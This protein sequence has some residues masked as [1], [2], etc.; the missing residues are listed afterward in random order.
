MTDEVLTKTVCGL[1]VVSG[2]NP[3]DRRNFSWQTNV[4]SGP[5]QEQYDVAREFARLDLMRQVGERVGGFAMPD[6]VVIGPIHDGAPDRKAWFEEEDGEDLLG[7]SDPSVS[8]QVVLNE[9]RASS[10]D[11]ALYTV[12]GVSMYTS[13]PI[14][15][16]VRAASALGAYYRAWDKQRMTS[17]EPLLLC[18]VHPGWIE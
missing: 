13:E 9:T 2:D 5:A 10:D 6:D 17:G 4:L 1:W 15:R 14:V 8:A 16:Q 18:A 3:Q 11:L 7:L 12:C